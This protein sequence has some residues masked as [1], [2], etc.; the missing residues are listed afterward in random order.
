MGQNQ[1]HF[2]VTIWF[3]VRLV[4]I[5]YKLY[6]CCW[7]VMYR[8]IDIN[9]WKVC[10]VFEWGLS[11]QLNSITVFVH[12]LQRGK[13]NE[14]EGFCY[15]MCVIGWSKRLAGNI[16]PIQYSIKTTIYLTGC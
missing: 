5:V 4:R 14:L 9:E 7:M 10:F 2:T 13:G 1:T 8:W 16:A 6:S 15:K 12:E 3:F 11:V